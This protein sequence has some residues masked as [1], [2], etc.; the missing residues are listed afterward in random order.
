MDVDDPEPLDWGCHCER[1]AD[2]LLTHVCEN[3]RLSP[4]TEYN[5]RA[6]MDAE[7]ETNLKE[8]F[9]DRRIDRVPGVVYAHFAINRKR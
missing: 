1:D 9:G 6:A 2:D 4:G 3:H 8:I 5:V 7:I